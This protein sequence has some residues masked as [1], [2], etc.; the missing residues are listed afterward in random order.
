VAEVNI[1]RLP[2][3]GKAAAGVDFASP[4]GSLLTAQVVMRVDSGKAKRYPYTWCDQYGCFARFG[5]THAEIKNMQ[6][7]AKSKI[8]IVAVADPKKPIT[9]TMSLKGFTAAWKSI[10]P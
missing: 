3:G 1:Q 10:A 6:K 7:G 9:L 8:T 5:L 2:D 4:L